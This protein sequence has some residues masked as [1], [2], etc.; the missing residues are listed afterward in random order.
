[1]HLKNIYEYVSYGVK[2]IGIGLGNGLVP[3]Q[4]QNALL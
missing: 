4:A 3:S 1:M 2:Y